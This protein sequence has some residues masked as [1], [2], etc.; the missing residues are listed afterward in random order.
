MKT[1]FVTLTHTGYSLWH[2]MT[3]ITM[4]HNW[5]FFLN[6]QL[7]LKFELHLFIVCAIIMKNINNFG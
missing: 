1:V 7:F 3:K 6:V 4:F 5:N 2:V